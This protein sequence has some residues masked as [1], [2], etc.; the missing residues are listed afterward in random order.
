MKNNRTIK[1]A[2]LVYMNEQ[3]QMAFKVKQISEGMKLTSSVD[4]KMLVSTLAKMEREGT[5]FLNKK[6]EFKLAEK[7][8]VLS[9]VFRASDRGFGFVSIEDQE[10]DILSLIHI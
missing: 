10:D 6:G 4:F 2:I 8:A 9:G 3:D 7:D 1:E 5:V